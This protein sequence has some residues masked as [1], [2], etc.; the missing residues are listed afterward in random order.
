MAWLPRVPDFLDGLIA[1][2]AGGLL[3]R[4]VS[5]RLAS[6]SGG[7]LIAVW[8]PFWVIVMLSGCL[9][10]LVLWVGWFNWLVS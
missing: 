9:S 5:C 1:L 8:L 4:S 7:C 6:L 10:G 2:L 3:L